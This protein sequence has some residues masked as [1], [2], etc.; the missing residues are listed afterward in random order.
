MDTNAYIVKRI[1][2]AKVT[3]LVI[4]LIGFFGIPA[5]WPDESM[6]FRAGVLLWY[7][8]FGAIIGLFGLF[9]E[10]PMF[11]F[12]MPCWFRG[13]VFG[14]WLNLVLVF[15]MHD[16][17]TALL[18]QMEGWGA[19]FSDPLWFAVEGSVMGLLID[20]VAT[21]IAGEGLPGKQVS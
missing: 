8:T 9:V 4:G 21:K 5:F 16:K 11:G 17:F 2:T 15:L 19:N 1:G 6:W 18:S 3:G 20:A 14:F 7:T 13:I 10:H 12:R